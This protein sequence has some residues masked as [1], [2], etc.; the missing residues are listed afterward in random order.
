MGCGKG[1]APEFCIV[2][3]ALMGIWFLISAFLEI[4]FPRFSSRIALTL[5]NQPYSTLY[6]IASAITGVLLVSWH[7]PARI[8]I[9]ILGALMLL[10]AP[11]LVFYPEKV[12]DS[13][14]EY[15]HDEEAGGTS[16]IE[17]LLRIDAFMRVLWGA[18]FL[19]SLF[20]VLL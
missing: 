10:N 4:A 2:F 20:T 18:T 19:Y 13:V 12:R 8:L 6:G 15:Q 9:M 17:K 5:L 1:I 7:G 3:A 14:D 11:F 16:G